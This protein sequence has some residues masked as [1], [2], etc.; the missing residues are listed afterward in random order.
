MALRLG[1]TYNFYKKFTVSGNVNYNDIVSSKQSDV[2]VT[3]FNTPNGQQI[4]H[5]ETGKYSRM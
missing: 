3:G 5:L 2:F 4:F 1:V